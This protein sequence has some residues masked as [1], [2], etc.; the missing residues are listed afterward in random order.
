MWV[1]EGPHLATFAFAAP[2]VYTTGA[3]DTAIL[4]D[5]GSI[6]AV[7]G[8]TSRFLGATNVGMM[9]VGWMWVVTAVETSEDLTKP[10]PRRIQLTRVDTEHR[11]EL[12]LIEILNKVVTSRQHC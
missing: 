2:L 5:S 3:M 8:K 9:G 10:A 11:V 1:S 7:C 6:S 12:C 4:S